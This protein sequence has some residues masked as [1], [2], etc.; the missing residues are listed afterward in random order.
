MREIV[1][2][3][4]GAEP[5]FAA[6]EWAA[7]EAARKQLPLRIVTVSAPWL[8]D[9]PADPKAGAVRA[10]LRESGEEVLRKAAVRARDVA[11]TVK[12]TTEGI[13]GGVAEA[14]LRESRT[15]E[16]LVIGS[17]G[18]GEVAGLILG[19]A[20][21][22]V[23]SHAQCPVVAVRALKAVV[24]SEVVV[25]V[26][27]SD[28]AQAAIEFAFDAAS[29]R[30][31]RLRAVRAWTHPAE[32]EHESQPPPAYDVAEVE[33]EERRQLAETLAGW[34]E[35]YP[36]VEVVEDVRHTSAARALADA[37]AAADLVVVGTRGRGGFA[38]LLLGSVSHALLHHVKCPIAVV[39]TG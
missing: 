39:P 25:G 36:D 29:R 32:T 13:P 22:Q 12:I 10:W 20:L 1:V 26:D 9:V 18:V 30:H 11:P 38:G 34:S 17:K 4:D 31:S 8:F 2:G 24:V 16:L 37:S 33:L 3:V 15:A 28:K 23:V 21:V 14:L 5:G 19:S 7:M 27:D 6:T 35:R